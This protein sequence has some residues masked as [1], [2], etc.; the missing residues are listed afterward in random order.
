MM[1]RATAKNNEVRVKINGAIASVSLI[2]YWFLS[3]G[4]MAI[5]TCP[6]GKA[7]LIKSK[8]QV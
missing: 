3:S 2:V 4:Q 6:F 7:V 5:T 8:T 1:N